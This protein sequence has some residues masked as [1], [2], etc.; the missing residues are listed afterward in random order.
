MASGPQLGLSLIQT[1][2]CPGLGSTVSRLPCLALPDLSSRRS[3]EVAEGLLALL[4]DP[5]PA[6][7]LQVVHHLLLVLQ[8]VLLLLLLEAL[9]LAL[10]PG[11]PRSLSTRLQLS[12]L[13]CDVKKRSVSNSLL[14]TRTC[15]SSNTTSLLCKPKQKQT[16]R[17]FVTPW[18]PRSLRTKPHN[19]TLLP[20]VLS[21]QRLF[22]RQKTSS[23]VFVTMHLCLIKPHTLL[24]TV[25]FRSA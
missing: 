13:R 1:T 21:T 24:G 14:L 12:T 22:L 19:A 10:G 15:S 4:A 20:G 8:A 25:T 16:C 3:R 17:H 5:A 6:R 23:A 9:P 11:V 18:R 2:R 7:L